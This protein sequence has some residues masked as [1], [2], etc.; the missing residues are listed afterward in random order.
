MP[1]ASSVWIQGYISNKK[2]FDENMSFIQ[3]AYEQIQKNHNY[4]FEIKS[5]CARDKLYY[6]F[7]YKKGTTQKEF[8]ETSVE[9][10]N[11]IYKYTEHHDTVLHVIGYQINFDS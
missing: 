4:N 2:E 1:F 3:P 9:V 11:S 8:W 6:E 5:V 7:K 10:F